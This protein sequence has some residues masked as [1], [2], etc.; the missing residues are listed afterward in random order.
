MF[1][2][3]MGGT[4]TVTRLC[5]RK[6][7]RARGTAVSRDDR[8]CAVPGTVNGRATT[9]SLTLLGLVDPLVKPP[10]KLVRIFVS[11][12]HATEHRPRKP[13]W[14]RVRRSAFDARRWTGQ[15]RR[16]AVRG[17]SAGGCACPPDH[18]GTAAL[19]VP[20]ACLVH[21]LYL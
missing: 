13:D 5:W 7:R 6:G 16:M 2:V 3:L 17:H 9:V 19:Q 15:Y 14:S 4:R 12:I 21:A 10:D 1:H 11:I 18:D 20:C 8:E